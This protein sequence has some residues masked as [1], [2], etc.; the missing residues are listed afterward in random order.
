MGWQIV[1]I[2]QVCKTV[3]NMVEFE[4]YATVNIQADSAVQ[5]L[6]TM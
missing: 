2:I 5:I 4:A 1:Q 6:W 3:V